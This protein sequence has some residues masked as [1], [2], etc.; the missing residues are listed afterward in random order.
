MLRLDEIKIL[1]TLIINMLNPNKHL[2]I[3][4][5]FWSPEPDLNF[6]T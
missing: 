1:K 3:V 2:H 5:R 6:R 4:L